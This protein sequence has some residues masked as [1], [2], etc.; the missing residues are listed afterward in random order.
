MIGSVKPVVKKK[1]GLTGDAF[2]QPTHN[3]SGFF[4]IAV[5]PFIFAAKMAGYETDQDTL[6]GA[7]QHRVPGKRFDIIFSVA[8][9]DPEK[10]PVNVHG[11]QPAAAAFKKDFI[12][13]AQLDIRCIGLGPEPWIHG[14]SDKKICDRFPQ[15]SIERLT[16]FRPG[17]RKTSQL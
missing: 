13:L 4:V 16:R 7:D 11:M 5:L 14:S 17:T 12:G 8:L 2:H 1:F 9:R 15:R 6:V 10:H 3:A